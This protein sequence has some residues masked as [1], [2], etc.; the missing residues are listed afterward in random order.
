M[1]AKK[2]IAVYERINGSNYIHITSVL[3]TVGTFLLVQDNFD[4]DEC[5]SM[6]ERCLAINFQQGIT[7]NTVTINHNLRDFHQRTA[8]GLHS[9]SIPRNEQLRIAQR[10]SKEAVRIYTKV[11]GATR[12][13]PIDSIALLQSL[14]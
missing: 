12:A 1:L 10:H 8:H 13:H 2:A 14:Q 5:R 6:F 7:Y 4:D 3:G 9:G 11:L